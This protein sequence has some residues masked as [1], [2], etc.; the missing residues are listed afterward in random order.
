MTDVPMALRSALP[1]VVWP[2]LPSP[3]GAALLAM[4]Y[5]LQHS[6]W[7]PAEQLR[8]RQLRQLE[9]LLRHACD[10]TDY[11]R[12]RF[13]AAG[14]DPGRVLDEA[15]FARLPLLTRA[16][17]QQSYGELRSR[18]VPPSSG[19][20]A[21]SQTSGST[22]MPVRFLTTE[23]TAFYW[24]VFTLRDHLWHR[25]DFGGKLAAIRLKVKEG[26]WPGWGPS[27]DAVIRSGPSATLDINRDVD[28]QLRWLER[29]NPDYL[30]T[31]A[32]N[33]E[34]L[35]RRS[36][37]LGIRLPALRE[38]RT[39]SEML[40]PGVRAL[41]HEAWGVPL[42][43]LYSSQEVGYIALQCPDHEHYHV[44]SENVRVE[45]LRDDG[46]PCAPGE[47]G[48]VVL[49]TLHNFAMPLIRY[50][51][52]DYAEA[53]AP[54]PCGRGLPVIRRVMGRVRNMVRLPD[55]G[56]H[57]PSL[58]LMSASPEGLIRQY[59]CIQHTLERI[60]VR[61]VV[62]RPLTSDEES[63]LRAA[64][65]KKIGHPFAFDITYCDQIE[66]SAGGKYE[67]FR[68]DIPEA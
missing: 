14:F 1:E 7:L 12:R 20:V 34:N 21:E 30:L 46:T 26:A 3:A 51:I 53:S 63:N 13:D 32:T 4:Q 56:R 65:V 16:Q 35:A 9:V 38:A 41:V 10:T 49:T 57:W 61:L 52:G 58:A 64:I 27:V 29:Q 17:L 67:E 36:L 60:E 45:V 54:C 8:A 33:M 59:Q 5:Q 2:A 55:G 24:R 43:D 42:T 37:D 15:A 6:Q 25:R 18:Q 28:E 23:L 47:V 66:R 22:G 19:R 31:F 44:Q 48:R 39:I 40:S 62:A 50:D 68:C 11:Y